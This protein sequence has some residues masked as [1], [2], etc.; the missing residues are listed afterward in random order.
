MFKVPALNVPVLGTKLTAVRTLDSVFVPAQVIVPSVN[1]TEPEASHVFPATLAIVTIPF[2]TYPEFPEFIRK[3]FV[4]VE[5]E[6]ADVPILEDPETYPV[7]A[8][9]VLSPIL[10]NKFAADVVLRAPIQTVIFFT[11]AGTSVNVTNEVL[12][13]F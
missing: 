7:A 9:P 8:T 4:A 3:Q 10:I 6:A 13:A 5:E 2:K 12:A 1:E 11:Q